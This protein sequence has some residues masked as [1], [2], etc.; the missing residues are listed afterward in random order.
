MK[1]IIIAAVLMMC[2]GV[3]GG[4]VGLPVERLVLPE[5]SGKHLVCIWDDTAGEWLNSF[6]IYDNKGAYD[7]QL[8]EWGKWYWVGLWDSDKSEYVFSKWIGHFPNS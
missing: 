3:F 8:P 1:K 7:F 5:V 6:E 4:Q 2:S